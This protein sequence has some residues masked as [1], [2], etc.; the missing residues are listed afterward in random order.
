MGEKKYLNANPSDVF[1]INGKKVKTV[2]NVKYLKPMIVTVVTI[3]TV[4][5]KKELARQEK[6]LVCTIQFYGAETFY[7]KQR[8]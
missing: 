2:K 6:F 5:L 7:K 4:K 8:N 3:V 1:E